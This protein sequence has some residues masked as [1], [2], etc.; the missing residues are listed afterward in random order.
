MSFDFNKVQEILKT[1]LENEYLFKTAFT[2]R[3]Y[4]NE[5][6]ENGHKS[7][8]RLEFLGDAVLQLISSEYLFNNYLNSP[9][10][11]MTNYRSAVVYHINR[12][13]GKKTRLWRNAFCYQ[14]VKKV[15]EA[16]KENIS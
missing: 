16:E 6:A 3:S 15:P 12:A 8:E 2:H 14:M 10:G 5:H 1:K 11:D 9:E 7:N 4:L 13:G